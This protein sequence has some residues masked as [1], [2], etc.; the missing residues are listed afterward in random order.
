MQ[1]QA[2]KRQSSDS[3]HTGDKNNAYKGVCACCVHLQHK[4]VCSALVRS[5]KLI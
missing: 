4:F 5:V 1:V 2:K 3:E